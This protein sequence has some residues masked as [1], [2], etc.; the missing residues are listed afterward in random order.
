MQS[1]DSHASEVVLDA[2]STPAKLLVL[3]CTYNEREN[4]P[5]LF[6]ALRGVAPDADF[7]V[8]D[9]RSPD[10]TADWVRQQAQTDPRVALIERSGKLG[11]G[12]AIRE[13]MKHAIQHGYEWLINLDGD[14]SHDPE[15]IVTMR[16]LQN[17]CDLAIGSR[18]VEG[19]GMQGCSWR[20]ILVS[21]CAN[22]LARGIVGWSIL[23]CS[24]AYRLYRVELLRRIELEEIQA[25]GY[26]FLEEVLAMMI[27]AG[28]RVIE[29]PI[30]YTE[31]Q[32]GRSKL[33]VREAIST[34][35]ALLR[36]AR[37]ARSKPQVGSSNV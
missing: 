9:D 36:I 5:K 6:D 4:L 32:Q 31:R 23:D 15:A 11:L 25:T 29:T 33:S 14:L 17:D 1:V 24:S 16:T 35:M 19:G 3:V 18:Y 13:G 22:W 27:R 30:V 2:S 37:I 10:G 26:G 8:V 12:T 21:R 28:A 34:F 20:R 7:L